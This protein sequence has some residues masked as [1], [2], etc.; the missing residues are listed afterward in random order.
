VLDFLKDAVGGE[1]YVNEKR[2]AA[3]EIP[4]DT[5]ITLQ[6]TRARAEMVLELVLQQASD[7]LT[8]VVRDGIVM[9]S[10]LEDLD[11]AAEVRVYNV[12]DLLKL[13]PAAGAMPG[14]GAGFGAGDFGGLAGASEGHAGPAAGP[15]GAGSPAFGPPGAGPSGAGDTYGAGMAEGPPRAYSLEDRAVMLTK[16]IIAATGQ[17]HWSDAGGFGTIAYY[18]GLLVVNHNAR[19]HQQVERLLAMLRSAAA[20][21]RTAPGGGA[22]APPA[23]DVEQ[24]DTATRES[25]AR[26]LAAEFVEA[27][28]ADVLEFLSDALGVEIYTNWKAIEAAAIPRD[29][30][31][32]IHLAKVRG[33]MALEL[34]LE[35]AGDQL[36]YVIR[37]GVVIV[38]TVED[39][40]G[41][42]MLRVYNCRDLLS[43]A[44]SQDV[45]QSSTGYGASMMGSPGPYGMTSGAA[46]M[47]MGA[48]SADGGMADAAPPASSSAAMRI[49]HILT[50]SIAPSSWQSTGGSGSGTIAEYNGLIVVNHNARVHAQVEQVLKM[51]RQAAAAGDTPAVIE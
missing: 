15:P 7:Q 5:P 32:T 45:Y 25:L 43:Q 37:D 19:L 39:L 2:L 14:M 31:V 35:Q 50:T 16:V 13:P 28:L 44:A 27:P 24:N 18:D 48:G 10:T 4:L 12:R 11:G 40:D 49:L 23:A 6:L 41:A 1:F 9:I 22:Q 17:Q 29:A 34:A 42:A 3:A 38:S 30:P 26:R 21:A 46:G 8:Y 33:A 36:A 20:Q 51:V 47:M